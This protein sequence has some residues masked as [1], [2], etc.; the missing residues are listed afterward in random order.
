MI[1]P[2]AHR[3]IYRSCHLIEAFVTLLGNFVG[4]LLFKI[5]D[6]PTYG[7][8]FVAVLGTA[9]VATVLPLAYRFISMWENKQ[10][11]KAGIVEGFDHAYEDDQTDVNVS[12]FYSVL[13]FI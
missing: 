8:G 12:N 11:D 5:E 3:V 13:L 7:P 9:A 10:R 4:P 1:I 2:S 6:A